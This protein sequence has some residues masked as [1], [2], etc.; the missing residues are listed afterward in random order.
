MVRIVFCVVGLCCA[1]L[2]PQFALAGSEVE[3][4]QDMADKGSVVHHSSWALIPHAEY[5]FGAFDYDT[6]V[7]AGNSSHGAAVG[8]TIGKDNN[9]FDIY[10]R[11]SFTSDGEG[12]DVNNFG[13]LYARKLRK[14]MYFSLG[15]ENQT[16]EE[17]DDGDFWKS[18][19]LRVKVGLGGATD[20]GRSKFKNVLGAG[21]FVGIGEVETRQPTNGGFGRSVYS[22][23]DMA[24]FGL[25]VQNKVTYALTD[26]LSLTGSLVAELEMS[27]DDPQ[28]GDEE[29]FYSGFSIYFRVGLQYLL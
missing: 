29:L 7:T 8:V 2:I 5:E 27:I 20:R 16:I 19:I 13:L 28:I 21:F 15:L 9:I 25:F 26:K 4:G 12:A 22:E 14:S 23:D 1:Y 11:Q 3:R 24:T 6:G 17:A 10:T 18:D